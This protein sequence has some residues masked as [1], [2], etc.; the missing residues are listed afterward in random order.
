MDVTWSVN[1]INRITDNRTPKVG[2]ILG[3]G[4]GDLV[5]SL[6]DVITIPCKHIPEFINTTI[7]GHKGNLVFGKLN[8]VEVVVLQGRNHYYEGYTMQ[9]I[10]YPVYVMKKL[11][12]ELLITTNAVGGL[13]DEYEVGDIMF[14]KDH[15][16]LMGSN[17][18]IGVKD[19]SGFVGMTNVYDINLI[20]TAIISSNKNKIKTHKGVLVAVVGPSYET[21]SEYK[22]MKIIGGD[23]VGMSTIPEVIVA[24]YYDLRVF[25]M[26]IVT[27]VMTSPKSPTHQ[28]VQKVTNDS[29]INVGMILNDLMDELKK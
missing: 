11:G 25:S 24:K 8:D 21:P 16:N 1:Y 12:V 14:V 4:L 23:A 9:Q 3:S 28:D 27:N 18:L 26:S 6:T 10:T 17:P 15:I 19:G 7:E 29:V 2:I 13:N 5:N 20:N 22:Y